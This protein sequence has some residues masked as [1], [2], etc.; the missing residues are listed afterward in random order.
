MEEI[1]LS[2][3][4]NNKNKKKEVAAA[5]I[6]VS[7]EEQKKDGHSMQNQL[8]LAN[9]YAKEMD[10]DLEEYIFKENAPASKISE[11]DVNTEDFTENFFN[12]PEFRKLLKLAELKKFNHLIVYSRDRLTRVT[13]EQITLEI[14]LKRCGIDIHYTRAG[15]NINNEN[16]DLSHF[17]SVILSSFAEYESGLLSTRIKDANRTCIKKGLWAGGRT[18]FGYNSKPV[19]E[20]GCKNRKHTTLEKSNLESSL[21]N[22]VFNLNKLGYGYRK[23][24][25]IMNEKHSYIKWTKSK[26]EVILNNQ[27]YTGMITWNRRGGRRQKFKKYDTIDIVQSDLIKNVAIVDKDTWDFCL[28][29]RI[30]RSASKDPYYYSTPFI[31]KGKLKCSKC[32]STM[33][34]KNPGKNKSNIYKCSSS[35]TKECNLSLPARK[36]HYYFAQEIKKIIKI[37]DCDKFWKIYCKKFKIKNKQY[38]IFAKLLDTKIKQYNLLLNKI[39]CKL[40]NDSTSLIAKAL[41]TQRINILKQLEAYEKT[42]S[43]LQKYLNIKQMDK[44]SFNKFIVTYTNS[45]FDNFDIEDADDKTISNEQ[46]ITNCNIVREFVLNFIDEVNI[47]CENGSIKL[48]KIIFKAPELT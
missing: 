13:E 1:Q 32:N 8:D 42:S 14:F 43:E 29:K 33:K 38:T 48:M 30:N 35:N 4:N 6:R 26:I 10:W 39:D 41:K 45:L 23:I 20:N 19:N 34:T 21:V 22:E 2:N 18:P 31:L 15:E 7:T 5:Y 3:I 28:N 16:D 11:N 25:S 37:D 46:I 24:A 40:K 9:E 36:V 47:E 44:L 27:T 17:L 12:R